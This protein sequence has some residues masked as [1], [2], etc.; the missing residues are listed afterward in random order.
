[1]SI[2]KDPKKRE[3]QLGNL[4]PDAATKH[5]LYSEAR[6]EPLRERFRAE[7]AEQFGA[8]AAADEL[9]LA[10][11][12]R[13]KIEVINEWLGRRGLLAD[14]RS[15]RPRAVL[16]LADRLQSAYERQL[17]DLRRRGGGRAPSSNPGVPIQIELTE[18]ERV[19]LMS[20]DEDVRQD[21]AHRILERIGEEHHEA[22]FMSSEGARERAR[23]RSRIDGGEDLTDDQLLEV[24]R[25]ERRR[26]AERVREREHDRKLT[27]AFVRSLPDDDLERL[28]RVVADREGGD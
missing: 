23:L 8:F 7:L 14:K 3:R 13:A 16:Q 1:M 15:G 21:T 22:W 18:A 11:D 9:A 5:G 27:R 10:A 4:R 25:D 19:G 6:L 12:R 20:S 24:K 2:S 17:A 26:Q 28:E